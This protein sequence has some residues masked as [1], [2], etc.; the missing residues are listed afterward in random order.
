MYQSIPGVITPL[1]PSKP[2]ASF[3]NLSNPN[4]MGKF[5]SQ[6]PNVPGFPVT[7]N[8]NIFYTYP[9]TIFKTSIIDLLTDYL[10]IRRK[11]IDLSMK[12][13]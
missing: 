2:R 6:I 8:D 1:P 13:M 10:Q 9:P 4:P 7:L 11:N 12:N 5:F 3:Q